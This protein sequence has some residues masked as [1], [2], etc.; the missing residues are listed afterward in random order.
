MANYGTLRSCDRRSAAA[1]CS[2]QGRPCAKAA[3]QATGTP[4]C[5]PVELVG[6][7]D[8]VRFARVG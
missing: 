7:A 4:E 3:H 6:M 1:G 8:K 2:H 5:I